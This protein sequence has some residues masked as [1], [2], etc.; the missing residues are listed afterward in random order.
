MKMTKAE[1]GLDIEFMNE[2]T[3]LEF[4]GPPQAE[5]FYVQSVLKTHQ[6]F[7]FSIRNNNKNTKLS[8]RNTLNKC[9]VGRK[10]CDSKS[11]FC[12]FH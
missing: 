3:N 11:A 6:D 1:N 12:H 5:I 10:T 7:D 2:N 8:L 4:L 9:R